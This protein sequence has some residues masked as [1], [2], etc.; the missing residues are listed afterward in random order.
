MARRNKCIYNV[1]KAS[2][3]RCLG[4][5]GFVLK[6]RQK[7]E[8]DVNAPRMHFYR[9]IQALPCP[10]L[11]AARCTGVAIKHALAKRILSPE[12]VC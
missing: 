7:K 3:L 9:D 10:A 12:S 11:P 4:K 2:A 6:N 5:A 8:A 1:N